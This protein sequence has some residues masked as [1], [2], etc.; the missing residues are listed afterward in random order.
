MGAITDR[1][2]EIAAELTAAGVRATADSGKVRTPC[3]LVVPAPRWDFQL[4]GKSA[5]VTWQLQAIAPLPADL[6]AASA[7]EELVAKVAALL[8]IESAVPGRY[9]ASE[10]ETPLPAYT[11]TMT[12]EV[13]L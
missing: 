4:A 12:D 3:V 5:L 9:K 7:L 8:P 13:E 10:A 2:K 6:T 11:L 1:A